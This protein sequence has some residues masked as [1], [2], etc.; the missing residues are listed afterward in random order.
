MAD[1]KAASERARR[2]CKAT[3]ANLFAGICTVLSDANQA[4]DASAAYTA[5]WRRVVLGHSHGIGRLH[6]HD[7]SLE[8]VEIVAESSDVADGVRGMLFAP[9]RQQLTFSG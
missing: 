7:F 3:F 9:L 6:L 5:E 8:T 1:A 4:D 2:E